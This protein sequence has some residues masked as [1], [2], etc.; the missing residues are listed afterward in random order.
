M[1][2]QVDL[3]T[4][5][6]P[7]DLLLYLVKREEVDVC[8]I[9]VAQVT[10][11][12]LTYLRMIESIDV[13]WAGEFLVMAAT[14]MEIKSR[15]LLPRGEME[16]EEEADP[17]LDLVRQL[18]E[19][20]KF[21]DAAAVLESQAELQLCRLPRQPAA[22]AVGPDP[23]QQPLQAVELWDL[24]S[25]FGRLMRE[26]LALQPKQIIMDET[27]IQV[28]MDQIV[29]RMEHEARLPFADIFTPPHTRG[30]L[31]GLFLAI[32]ELIKGRK[33]VVEQPEPF[34][35]IWVCPAPPV[36]DPSTVGHVLEQGNGD[37]LGT[38]Q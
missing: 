26:T 5:R 21:K 17:R 12:F 2:Y 14:L 20:K 3:T 33:I 37:N 35:P 28:Y 18:I 11:Q 10:E 31:L 23:K 7:L 36:E 1:D 19:Y 34:A 32:L 16:G 27:P 13:E 22:A 6:G 4:F 24:V 29:R 38:H 8:D 15:M 30:R 9:P 25:A